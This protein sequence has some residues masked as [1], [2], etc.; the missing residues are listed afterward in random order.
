MASSEWKLPP[1]V[2]VYEALGAVGD[3]RVRIVDDTHAIVT[4]STGK[5]NYN[6]ETSLDGREISSNDNASYWQ[7]YLGY[8]GIAVLIARG[9]YRPPAN[10]IDALAGVAWKELNSRFRNNYEKTIAEVEKQVE[11]SGHDPDAA[12][13]EAEALL[14][15]LKS[16]KPRRGMRRRP[17][18]DKDP[19]R[20]NS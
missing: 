12:R 18:S 1:I 14:E 9:Y 8:P 15:F 6:V 11:D 16:F 13:S 4:S 2:K 10:V 17:P 20:K 19:A 3:G 5:K 7:D